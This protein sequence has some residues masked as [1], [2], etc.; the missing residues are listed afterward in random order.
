MGRITRRRF[1]QVA[2]VAALGCVHAP[3]SQKD[4]EQPQTELPSDNEP[5]RRLKQADRRKMADT[6]FADGLELARLPYFELKDGRLVADPSIGPVI[7]VHTH[8]AMAFLLPMRLDLFSTAAPAEHY[9]LMQGRQVD[10]EVYIN[11]NFLPDD[12]TRMKKD[13]TLLSATADG[14]RKTHTVGNLEREMA[15]LGIAHSVV[16]P[17]DYPILSRNT[18]TTLEVAKDRP[19]LIA[20]GSVHPFARDAK[21]RLGRQVKA[22]IRGIKLHPAMQFFSPDHPRA[23]RLYKLCGEAKLPVLWHCGPV[24][25]E[26]KMS[27][28]LS[29]VVLY[30]KPIAEN[31]EVTFILGHSGAL[32]MEQALDYAKRYPNV[33]LEISCQSLTNV[34]RILEEADADRI[35][36][37]TDWPFYHQAIALAKVLIA[38]EGDARLRR[39]VLYTNA[40]SLF[41]I[42]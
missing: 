22:G 17:I 41:G 35:M 33:F 36:Y 6:V 4:N 30:E 20:F 5:N 2:G 32:Q 29:Q 1:L 21:G 13:L 18:E 40:A 10:L 26:P 42:G 16:L 25:I 37:G 27:R 14:M 15:E 24:G 28:E 23:M 8:I 39:K 19:T 7:D 12:L 3:Q 34:R 9:L 38:T 31:P 11:K